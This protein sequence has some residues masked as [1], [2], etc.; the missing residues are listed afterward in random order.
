MVDDL[1]Q[2]A[3]KEVSNRVF[4]TYRDFP[5]TPEQR[6]LLRPLVRKELDLLMQHFFALLDNVG[7]VLPEGVL[8]YRLISVTNKNN[9]S[10][11]ET[12]VILENGEDFN[13]ILR[14]EE[15]LDDILQTLDQEDY[16]DIRYDHEDYVMMWLTHLANRGR[17]IILNE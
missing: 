1:M 7:S 8:A 3:A 4:S 14:D 11:N 16:N 17:R 15:Y 10:V 13:S 5:W 9:I 2:E 6:K 12:G